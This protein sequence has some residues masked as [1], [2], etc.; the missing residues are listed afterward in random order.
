MTFEILLLF[1]L[2]VV[3]GYSL[4]SGFLNQTIITLPI[5][6]VGLGYL[7]SYPVEHLAK[8]ETLHEI[9]KVI[10]EITL[11]IVLFADASHVRWA[12]LAESYQI[13]VRM[14]AIGM[15]LTI[16]FG[17]VVVF[18]ISP[19]QS[20]AVAFLTAAI[21]TP[22]DAALGQSVVTSKDVPQRLSQAINVESGL[23]DGLALPF[24]LIAAILAGA[25]SMAGEY[26]GSM[27]LFAFKQ[28]TLGPIAGVF[29]GWS[30]ARLLDWAQNKDLVSVSSQGVIF[31][32]TAFT[33]YLSAETLGGN[34]FIAAFVAGAVF[35]NTYKHS[36]T[37]IEEFMEGQGQLL[38]MAAFFIFGSVL[39]PIGIAHISWVAVALGVLFLTVIRMLPIWISLS[40]MGMRPK[41]KLFLGW[42]GPRGLA[43]ILFALLIVDEFEIPHEKELLACVVMTVF[44]SI[45][46]HGI[47]SNPLAKRIDK[48]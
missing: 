31:L 9:A 32:T 47:S 5:V 40:A 3:I 7:V 2:V 33:A 25:T 18:L 29:V 16:L 48:N 43:S 10:A 38:T 12:R 13:P 45:I 36:L 37:F 1:I 21:L 20:W 39:L 24:I 4:V 46:L 42:F 27:T 41:E 23:N 22:T 28:V 44:L 26:D 14:L 8:E 34:G 11:I 19:A 30:L 35:G 17:T 15:P 6:F